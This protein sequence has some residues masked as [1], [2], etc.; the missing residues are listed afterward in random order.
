MPR[1]IDGQHVPTMVRKKPGLQ[2]PH[3]VVVEHAVDKDGGRLRGVEGFAAGV[4]VQ[5]CALNSKKHGSFLQ[6][7]LAILWIVTNSF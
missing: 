7:K 1:Q 6:R 3:A 5:A 2:N 4:G